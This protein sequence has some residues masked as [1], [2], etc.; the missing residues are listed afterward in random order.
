ML[1]L[2]GQQQFSQSLLFK[3]S[4][5]KLIKKIIIGRIFTTG[6]TLYSSYLRK[7]GHLEDNAKLVLDKTALIHSVMEHGLTEPLTVG[8]VARGRY[9]P[10]RLVDGD[11]RLIIAKK[12]GIERVICR[13]IPPKLR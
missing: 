13:V 3:E 9:Y 11:H 10:D 2:C 12:L 5:K 8:R 4:F 6:Q 1:E 7:R